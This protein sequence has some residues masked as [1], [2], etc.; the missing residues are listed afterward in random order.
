MSPCFVQGGTGLLTIPV[1]KVN[2]SQKCHLKAPPLVLPLWRKS[3]SNETELKL[4]INK[5]V[6]QFRRPLLG[7][8]KRVFSKE[9]QSRRRE[10][11]ASAG[12]CEPAACAEPMNYQ[13]GCRTDRPHAKKLPTTR[14]KWTELG[15]SQKAT[16]LFETFPE[17]KY[18]PCKGT[19]GRGRLFIASFD[20]CSH[21]LT[22]NFLY[23]SSVTKANEFNLQSNKNC[24]WAS[25]PFQF[26]WGGH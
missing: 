14:E 9:W 4:I 20:F 1:E 8:G 19:M 11:R 25:M 23:A 6:F 7:G 18:L 10:T 17:S 24:L 12:Y 26:L 13:A 5:T 22:L 3:G 2:D 21:L 16:K 15:K